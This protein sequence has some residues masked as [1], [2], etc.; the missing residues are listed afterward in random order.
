MLVSYFS[1][2]RLK[3]GVRSEEV[4][5]PAGCRTVSDLVGHLSGHHPA[6]A[7]IAEAQG[8]MR[9]TVNRRYVESSHVL[10]AADEVGLFPPVTGG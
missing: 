5:L 9:F 8:S 3:T 10:F 2:L 1:W 6:L 7:A 4:A